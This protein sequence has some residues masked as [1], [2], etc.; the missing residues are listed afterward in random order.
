[1]KIS[2]IVDIVDGKLLSSPSIS[3]INSIKSDARKVR[4]SD[5]FIAR[6]IED[7]KLA[8]SNGAYATI[9]EE[10]FE[11]I[12]N[13]VAF[14]KVENL[15][16]A[17][18]K[19]IRYKLSN[20]T[21]KAFFCK[22]ETFDM[23]KLYKNNP[24]KPFFLVPKNIEKIF[25]FIDDIKNDDI[26]ISKNIEILNNIYPKN[27]KF[28]KNIDKKSIKNLTKHSL[29]ELSFSY[30][31]N[32]FSRIR[33]SSL[34]LDV[35]LNI[36]NFLNKDIDTTKLKLYSNLKPI[37]IDKNFQP[38]EFGKSSGFIICQSNKDL[39]Q[40]E[41]AY[42]K[43]EFNYA[44]TIFITKYYID[45]ISKDEQSIIQNIS[46]IKDILKTSTFNC[47]YLIGF[48]SKEIYEYLQKS[49]NGATLF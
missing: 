41:I 31:N 22:S 35:F 37:F 21:L 2:S 18:I 29:F 14:I 27:E 45:F 44:K 47:V 23:L 28:E 20:L 13:E 17:I 42:I 19:L 26:L 11:V 7:L 6:N 36:Y 46:D 9:F 25:E 32:Y 8:I 34:Y 43:K 1:M 3:F 15:E 40:T 4:I 12:D 48:N 16:L 10:N 49:Q 24:I 38:I 5:L 30:E 33:L 39:I